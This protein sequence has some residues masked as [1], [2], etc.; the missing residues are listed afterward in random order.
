MQRLFN[1]WATTLQDPLLATAPELPVPPPMAQR[2]QL[3]AGEFCDLTLDPAGPAPEIVRVTASSGGVLTLGG[4][5]LEGSATPTSWPAGTRVVLAATARYLEALQQ[6]TGG[7]GPG[8]AVLVPGGPSSIPADTVLIEASSMGAD[9]QVTLPAP[10]EGRAY[11]MD[12]R[13]YFWSHTALTII[14]PAGGQIGTADISDCSL[15]LQPGRVVIAA[16][17]RPKWARVVITNHPGEGVYVDIAEY[18]TGTNPS[19]PS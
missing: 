14:P 3:A 2:L 11:L 9:A 18:Y 7:G 15:D 8:R 13:L 1:N 17:T 19:A 4:R 16:Q 6:P 5:G 10:P 12:L